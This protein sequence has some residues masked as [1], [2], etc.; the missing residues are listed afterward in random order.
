MH[1][2]SAVWIFPFQANA[3]LFFERGRRRKMGRSPFPFSTELKGIRITIQSRR[4]RLQSYLTLTKALD[5]R[6]C[7][8]KRNTNRLP[9][10][11][12]NK[13]LIALKLIKIL[14]GHCSISANRKGVTAATRFFIHYFWGLYFA[15]CSFGFLHYI[16]SSCIAWMRAVLV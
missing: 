14:F 9:T 13:H 6:S 11:D 5:K 8:F 10:K 15:H 4:N 2:I 1:F 3:G 7:L 12:S 16:N